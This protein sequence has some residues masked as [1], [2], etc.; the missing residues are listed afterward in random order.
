MVVNIR[1]MIWAMR[2]CSVVEGAKSLEDHAASVCR[3]RM[4]AALFLQMLVPFC[5]T[6]CQQLQ[7]TT[8]V[9]RNLPLSSDL[10]QE[11]SIK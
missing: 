2:P 1:N 6:V 10:E 5:S 7:K 8:L 4:E 11:H 3:C 9:C